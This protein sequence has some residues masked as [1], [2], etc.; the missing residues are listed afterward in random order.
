M[1]LRALR[2]YPTCVKSM[3]GNKRGRVWELYYYYYVGLVSTSPAYILLHQSPYYI[4][5]FLSWSLPRYISPIIHTFHLPAGTDIIIATNF[6]HS[7]YF[8]FFY[9][10]VSFSCL[11]SILES[12]IASSPAPISS[13][14]YIGVA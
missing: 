13:R 6:N 14:I 11:Y 1:D 12:L 3:A 10:V 8:L 2:H 9:I 4:I 5:S 7:S